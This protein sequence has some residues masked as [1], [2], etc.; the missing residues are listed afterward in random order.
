M[1]F[2]KITALILSILLVLSFASCQN[3]NHG[4]DSITTKKPAPVTQGNLTDD[5]SEDDE[6][7]DEPL[8]PLAENVDVSTIEWQSVTEGADVRK[9]NNGSEVSLGNG[10][11]KF[12]KSIVVIPGSGE[13]GDVEIVYELTDMF[14]AFATVVGIDDSS[15]GGSVEFLIY[16]DGNLTSRTGTMKKGEF[17][18]LTAETYGCS[19]VKLVVSNSDGDND[20][21]IAVFGVPTLYA[22]LN[23]LKLEAKLPKPVDAYID[24]VTWTSVQCLHSDT[25]GAPFVDKDESGNTLSMGNGLFVTPKGLWMHPNYGEGAWAEVVMDISEIGAKEF[26]AVFGLSDE[27]V[28]ACNGYGGVVDVSRRSVQFVFLVDDVEVASF[29][30]VNSVKLA[31]VVIDVSKATTFTIRLTNYDGVHTCDASVITAGFVC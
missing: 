1:N 22:G 26:V 28:G 27:Y 29:D 3:G 20:G 15:A 6:T 10:I 24:E 31:S 18:Y 25:K 2:R 9:N 4:D 14:F 13:G 19:E 7:T 8:I 17:M 23:V 16:V 30:F 5:T 12:D 11:Y 21:D